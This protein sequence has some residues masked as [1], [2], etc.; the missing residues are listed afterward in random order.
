MIKF[1]TEAGCATTYAAAATFKPAVWPPPAAPLKP[2]KV[3]EQV[4]HQPINIPVSTRRPTF[5]AAD[6]PAAKEKNT[7]EAVA[8]GF[9]NLSIFEAARQPKPNNLVS[10]AH[11]FTGQVL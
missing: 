6:D 8:E 5:L 10:G 4:P 7:K 3:A 11:K 2:A 1:S 9:K